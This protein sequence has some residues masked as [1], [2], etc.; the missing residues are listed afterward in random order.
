MRGGLGEVRSNITDLKN[1][2]DKSFLKELS[3]QN[4][5]SESKKLEL[6]SKVASSDSRNNSRAKSKADEA[7]SET[8]PKLKDSP[9][10]ESRTEE[11]KKPEALDAQRSKGMGKKVLNGREKAIQKFMDSV[12]S[13]FG[14]PPQRIV[15][16]MAQ[17]SDH[18]LTES[19]DL[20]AEKI[21]DNLDLPVEQAEQMKA[22]YLQFVKELQTFDNDGQKMILKNDPGVLMG[23]QTQQ[24]HLAVQSNSDNIAQ[25]LEKLN[26]KFWMK[27]L[28][29]DSSDLGATVSQGVDE[30]LQSADLTDVQNFNDA[31]ESNLDRI[32]SDVLK[33]PIP[34]EN[35]GVGVQAK[36][37]NL[38]S[39]D[40]KNILQEMTALKD[41]KEKIS[42][43]RNQ[44]Q[45]LNQ[46][47]G[48]D[49]QNG[50]AVSTL[51]NQDVD[52]EAEGDSDLVMSPLDRGTAE[53]G[54]IKAEQ[55]IS[56]GQQEFSKDSNLNESSKNMSKVMQANS[57]NEKSGE[58]FKKT[59]SGEKEVE[60]G[61]SSK[62]TSSSVFSNLPTA[63]P[64][65]TLNHLKITHVGATAGALGAAGAGLSAEDKANV[66]QVMNQA[67]YLVKNGG[68]EV[69]VQMTPEGMGT[70]QLKLDL[71]D[72]K[73]NVQM[74]ADNHETKKILEDSLKDLKNSL[75]SHKLSV[76]HVKVDVVGAPSSEMGSQNNQNMNSDAQRDSTRQFWNQ[77][78]ENFGNQSRDGY[79][80]V[81]NMNKYARQMQKG[82]EL[83]SLNETSSQ[84]RKIEGRGNGLNMVA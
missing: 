28:A 71:K 13:E 17:L 69:K 33:Q 64:V 73:V 19:P 26:Q 18:D 54:N 21:V 31:K 55:G 15:E 14:I 76:D 43:L 80:E 81:P 12:E 84:S 61:S 39:D 37:D 45:Q 41:E 16:S 23:V 58:A 6:N 82:P 48:S 50:Q 77:Y 35:V 49:V 78:R 7:G 67:Q 4:S 20:N 2:D 51:N 9:R 57:E 53:A 52:S 60:S 5:R 70:V 32:S 65:D 3:L 63:V 62:S 38:D 66:Q 59:M 74:T 46:Q 1:S 75:S 22:M 25:G 8:Q 24:R 10:K 29:G 83:P 34:K 72:G 27:P 79:F 44:L 11:R 42:S 47:V 40:L 56:Q 30:T 68:G 36:L